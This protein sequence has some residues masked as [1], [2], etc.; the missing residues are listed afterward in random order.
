M[1]HPDKVHAD[2]QKEA[3][4]KFN[5]LNQAYE[6]LSDDSKR[7]MYDKHGMEAF[8]TS[9]GGMPGG[10]TEEELLAHLFGMAGGIPPG[11]GRAAGGP[12]RPQRGPNEHQQYKVTLEELY[13][14]K[15]ARFSSTRKIKCAHCDGQGGKDPTKGRDC[16]VCRGRSK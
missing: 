12:R 16:G 4:I 3:G 2:D 15:S 11:F 10:T 14:G 9:R 1:T 7:D 8:D 5:A 13:K 6:I